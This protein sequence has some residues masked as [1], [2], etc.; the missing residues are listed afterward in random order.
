MAAKAATGLVIALVLVGCSSGAGSGGSAGTAPVRL[1]AAASAPIPGPTVDNATTASPPPTATPA[2]EVTRP[3]PAFVPP[4]PFL[5]TPPADYEGAWYGSAALWTMLRDGG[6]VWGPWVRLDGGL[7]Q[8]TFWWSAAWVPQAEL[9]PAI[10][11]VGRRIDR[12]GSF[13]FGPGTNASA[14]F[15]T[16]MLVGIDLPDYG[17]WEITGRYRGASLSYVVAVVDH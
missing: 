8:K 13:R 4:R 3:D 10:T 12:P 7:P 17:C 11:V 14:D 5:A 1:A 16:A 2:C 6:D 15:G 9:E